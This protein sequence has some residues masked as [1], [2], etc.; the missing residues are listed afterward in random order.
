MFMTVTMRFGRGERSKH[1]RQENILMVALWFTGASFKHTYEG[2]CT[3]T[4]M[5][6]LGRSFISRWW[7]GHCTGEVLAEEARDKAPG[8]GEGEQTVQ[9][10]WRLVPRVK[11]DF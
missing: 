3:V 2:N 8:L 7:R 5:G 4:S 1:S 10:E 6:L 11:R 9:W